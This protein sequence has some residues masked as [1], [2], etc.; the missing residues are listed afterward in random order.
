MPAG[1]KRSN[2][3]DWRGKSRLPVIRRILSRDTHGAW[4]V[5]QRRGPLENVCVT[6]LESLMKSMKLG[7]AWRNDDP[8]LASRTF[9]ALAPE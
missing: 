1:V 3:I 2:Q 4:T 9:D 8:M 5:S 7:E 6:C